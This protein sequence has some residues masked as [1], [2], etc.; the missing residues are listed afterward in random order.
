[1]GEDA[2]GKNALGHAL[3]KQDVTRRIDEKNF[4]ET[5]AAV[6]ITTAHRDEEDDEVRRISRTLEYYM[7]LLGKHVRELERVEA[8]S[9]RTL[10]E[11]DELS[12]AE[13]HEKNYDE[14][15]T[16]LNTAIA[17]RDAESNWSRR[18]T[19]ALA[20]YVQRQ[21][22]QIRIL[23]DLRDINL[24]YFEESTAN[25][26][27]KVQAARRHVAELAA[28]KERDIEAGPPTCKKQKVKK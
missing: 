4:L 17:K 22:E 27:E 15:L 8:M 9:R 20:E 5:K 7:Y 13:C 25:W 21:G 10:A 23:E 1:V 3:A 18:R 19:V 14:S 12:R 11:N 6:D 26:A 24:R 2:D 28:A 16:A